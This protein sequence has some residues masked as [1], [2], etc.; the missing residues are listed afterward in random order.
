MPFAIAPPAPALRAV[1]LGCLLACGCAGAAQPAAAAGFRPGAYADALGGPA[2]VCVTSEHMAR[3]TAAAWKIALQ[4]RGVDCTLSE[5][6]RPMPG[7]ETWAASCTGPALGA[8]APHHYRFTVHADGDQ[9]VIDSSM[10]ASA[11]PQM[12]MTKKAFAGR[13]QGACAPGHPPLDVEAYLDGMHGSKGTP[14]QAG[15]R[16]AVALDLIRCGHVFN[17]LSLG[18]AKPRQEGTRAA[19]AAMI[20]AAVEL[21]PGEGGFHLEA[22]RQS[23]PEVSA[24]LV[25]AP[26]EKKFALYQSCSPYLEP[27]G[28]ARAVQGRMA[29]DAAAR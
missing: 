7:H 21:H 4:Q 24:E 13:Y 17:G 9:L 12:M 3:L 23:A 27:E 20:A 14:A 6:A 10:A 26:A 29:A 25:G 1:L 28:V 22:L 2:V 11:G 15:A 18:V 19:A 5:S 8:S 16:K